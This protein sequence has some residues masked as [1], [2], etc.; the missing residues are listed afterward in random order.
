MEIY[1][2]DNQYDENV[3]D[4]LVDLQKYVI[5][6][7]KYNLNIISSDYRDKYFQYMLNDCIQGEGKVFVAIENDL[8]LG[9]IAGYVQKYGNR[10][11][12][13]YLCPKKGIVSE[14]IVSTNARNKGI[15][16][17]LLSKMENYFKSI[18][19]EYI[20][21]DVFAYNSNAISFYNKNGYEN[22]MITM[23]KKV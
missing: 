15:G 6:I 21:L 22:R 13:D 12:L 9:M 4:L 14:L 7:D 23:F 17:K 5:S 1:E 10:D 2:F 11:K 8:C 19:C 3:K 16:N 18:N 20:Q